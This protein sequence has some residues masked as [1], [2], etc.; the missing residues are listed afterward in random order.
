MIICLASGYSWTSSNMMTLS[1]SCSVT[2]VASWSFWKS[3][4]RSWG[5]SS[6]AAITSSSAS[7]KSMSMYDLYSFSANWVATVVLP[8]RLA[9]SIRRAVLPSSSSFHSFS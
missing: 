1:R 4:S 8:T 6:K 5:C 3:M 2:P 9:P 7:E